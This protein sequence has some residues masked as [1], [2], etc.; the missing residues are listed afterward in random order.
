IEHTNFM[1]PERYNSK[2]ILYLSRYMAADDPLLQLSKDAL[3]AHYL[4]HLR[5][6]NPAFD[7]SWIRD[8]WLFKDSQAQPIITVGYKALQPSFRTPV[9]DLFVINTTQIYPEDRGTNY[10]VRL[11]RQVAALM[12][13]RGPERYVPMIGAGQKPAPYRVP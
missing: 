6:I 2:H 1:P 13:G 10:A 4:P 5:R 3:L 8:T 12:L 11:G 9:P 7:E